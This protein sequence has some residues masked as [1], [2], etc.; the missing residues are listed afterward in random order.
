M[1]D[2]WGSQYDSMRNED[3][4]YLWFFD[5]DLPILI[6]TKISEYTHD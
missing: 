4:D 3:G 5:L 6:F 2:L 1:E